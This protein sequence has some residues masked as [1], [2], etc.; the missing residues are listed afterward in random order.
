MEWTKIPIDLLQS[1]KSDN[2]ILA[3]TKYQLL[4][5]M[6]ERKPDDET[7]LRYMTKK[8]LQQANNFMLSIERCVCNDIKSVINSRKRQKIFYEKNQTLKENSNGKTNVITNDNTNRLT[9]KADKIREDKIILDKIKKENIIKEKKFKKPT[10]EE[11]KNYCE[12]RNNNISAEKFYDFYES[13]G[14]KVGNQPMKDWQASVR[15]WERKD[16][17]KYQTQDMFGVQSG[18]YGKDIP[19]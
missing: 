7:A 1:R 3:I 19:L 6:L 9:T 11:I 14:W 13:K 2:E 8:Q 18:T 12:E 16:N 17:K 4:W 15:T 10:I 5:A